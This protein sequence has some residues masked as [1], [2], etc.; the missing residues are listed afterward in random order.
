MVCAA[1][2]PKSKK[3]ILIIYNYIYKTLMGEFKLMLAFIGAYICILGI[4][5]YN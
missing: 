5:F 3:L 4:V 2:F 1:G